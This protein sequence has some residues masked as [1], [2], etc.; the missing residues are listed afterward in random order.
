MQKNNQFFFDKNCSTG[1]NEL[2][3]E[4]NIE[5]DINT[6]EPG[7]GEINIDESVTVNVYDDEKIIFKGYWDYHSQMRHCLFQCYLHILQE[8]VICLHLQE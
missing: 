2:I 3:V 7:L 4:D 6:I 1:Q 8:K 5:S